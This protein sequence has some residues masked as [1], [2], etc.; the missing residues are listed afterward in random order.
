MESPES[1][2][3]H[4]SSDHGTDR[5]IL[6]LA[7]ED[8]VCAACMNLP[9]GTLLLVDAVP[10]PLRQAVNLGHKIARRAIA[11]GKKI[12]KHGAAIGSATTPIL[13]GDHGRGSVVGSAISPVIKVC[14]NPETYRRM[15]EDMDVDAGPVLEGRATLDQVGRE[16]FDLVLAVAG[17]QQTKSETLGHQ[18]FILA[19][20]SF[21]PIGPSC[22][23][24]PL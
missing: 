17:G 18:E 15:E 14:A 13:A 23:P 24:V 9:A 16:V 22:L 8:N 12:V 19:Y 7:P 4:Q 21:Q 3:G 2:H 10:V 11:P 6:I 20:K 5:R 1:V